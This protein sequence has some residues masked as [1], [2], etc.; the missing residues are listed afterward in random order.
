MSCVGGPRARIIHPE[1]LPLLEDAWRAHLATG[2]PFEMEHRVRRADGQYRWHWTRRVALRDDSGDVVRWYGVGPDATRRRPKF[3]CVRSEARLASPARASTDDRHHP[4]SGRRLPAGRRPR[5]RQ[6]DLAQLY[7]AF[8]R[9]HR[10]GRLDARRSSRRHRGGADPF[11]ASGLDKGEPF[12]AEECAAPTRTTGH[13]RARARGRRAVSSDGMKWSQGH[14]GP[15]ARRRSAA[16]SEA[17]LAEAERDLQMTIDTIPIQVLS[18]RPDGTHSHDPGLGG[19]ALTGSQQDA[20]GRWGITVHPDDLASVPASACMARER[21][22]K[23]RRV[24]QMR[25]RR[26]GGEYRWQLVHRVPLRDENGNV[27]RW[28]GVGSDIEDQ[29]RVKTR[30]ARA[31][32]SRSGPAAQPYRQLWLECRQRRHRLVME[33]YQIPVS[34]APS[35]R[36]ST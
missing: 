2:E 11:G 27:I 13:L 24:M 10:R 19:G 32:L 23:D 4:G 7:R 15:E 35:R 31:R 18:Y 36:P 21:P 14:R 17:H 9:R 1:D 3:R 33:A 6:P 28:Y 16:P 34:T 30:C 8:P 12:Q 5:F 20:A 29:K 25:F 26:A 22:T